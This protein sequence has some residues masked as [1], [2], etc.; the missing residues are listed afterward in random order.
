MR[1]RT[2]L[3]SAGLGVAA[4]GMSACTSAQ[5]SATLNA[6]NT[7]CLGVGPGGTI[8]ATIVSSLDPALA[9]VAS[10]GA[11]LTN[12]ISSQCPAFIASVQAVIEDVNHLGGTATVNVTT[13]TATGARHHYHLKVSRGGVYVVPPYNPFPFFGADH[14][15]VYVVPP[16]FW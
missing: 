8:A 15:A 13:T 1:L 14:G 2:L 7:T 3:L 11:A 5:E 10:L 9:P 16:S 6:I 12:E 4:L